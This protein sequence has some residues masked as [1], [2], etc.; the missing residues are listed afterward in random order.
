LKQIVNWHGV[1]HGNQKIPK[2]DKMTLGLDFASSVSFCF[3]RN[4]HVNLIS[5]HSA[6]GGGGLIK[7]CIQAQILRE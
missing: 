7:I 5:T 3:P 6:Q 1:G 4:V 2:H